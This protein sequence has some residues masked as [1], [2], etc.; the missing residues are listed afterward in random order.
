M[1]LRWLSSG[2]RAFST[3]FERFAAVPN[4]QKYPHAFP[5]TMTFKEYQEKYGVL[6]AKARNTDEPVALAG[7]KRKKDLQATCS[8]AHLKLDCCCA[9]F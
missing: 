3:A 6:P 9:N 8:Y 5:V 7:L 2:R 4:I 1:H